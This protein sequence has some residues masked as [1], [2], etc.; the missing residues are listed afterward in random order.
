MNTYKRMKND[1]AYMAYLAQST[2]Y[3][4]I[5]PEASARIDESLQKLGPRETAKKD[6]YILRPVISALSVM[7]VC[8]ATL[9][10]VNFV[11]PAY[12]EE[13]PLVGP[14]FQQFNSIFSR[15]AMDSVSPTGTHLDSYEKEDVGVWLTANPEDTKYSVEVLESY[16]DSGYANLSLLLHLPE[17]MIGVYEEYFCE[18]EAAVGGELCNNGLYY[19]SRFTHFHPTDDPAVLAG[20]VSAELP[21]GLSDGESLELT[22]TLRSFTGLLADG[23]QNGYL[24]EIPEFTQS[25][26]LTVTEE[27]SESFEVSAESGD[28]KVYGISVSPSR[29]TITAD[30]PF[31]VNPRMVGRPMADG[32]TW[33]DDKLEQARPALYTN[34]GTELE[35]SIV[36]ETEPDCLDFYDR[37]PTPEDNR[38]INMAFDGVPAG[39][40]SVTLRWSHDV[41]PDYG[42]NED[43]VIAEFTF[44]LQSG[45]A[46]ATEHYLD[47][48]SPLQLYRP[49]AFH[50]ASWEVD[51][52]FKDELFAAETGAW[53]NGFQLGSLYI[54]NYDDPYI[55]LQI[56][57]QDGYRQ[58]EVQVWHGGELLG[59]VETT[60]SGDMENGYHGEGSPEF[61]MHR[62]TFP[63]PF[64]MSTIY[65]DA[66]SISVGDEL[67]I[68]V[69]DP[70]T[71]EV[72]MDDLIA[73]IKFL[74]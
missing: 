37:I 12:A 19:D 44:D 2:D 32:S 61:E 20:A 17:D 56:F 64:Y 47:K 33:P 30:V 54:S 70:G 65:L 18:G 7:A 15:A 55:E 34:D 3:Q 10:T 41:Y 49:S 43:K 4:K 6:R 68:R 27:N 59:S 51:E 63:I 40:E 38:E 46:S 35:F 24:D 42:G 26:P 8:V 69:V 36:Y 16:T 66:G 48:N 13:L 73:D 62:D 23:G 39:T 31:L 74:W 28:Y 58:A 53:Q 14:L 25:I 52:E 57:K 67:E 11:N 45:T 22:V 72:L 5:T 1:K 29:T 71:G 21:K 9:F 60:E 50:T